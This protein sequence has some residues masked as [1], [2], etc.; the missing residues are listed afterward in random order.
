MK[1]KLIIIDLEIPPSVKRWG[2]RLGIPLAVLI[3]GSTIAWA[4]MLHTWNNG[5]RLNADDLNGNFATLQSEIAALQQSTT[6]LQQ[7]THPASAFRAYLTTTSGLNVPN[8]SQ[9][10][11]QFNLVDYDLA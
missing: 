10:P 9:T 3:G 7:V 1:V 4:A 11:V 8:D 5:D 2:I 6:A